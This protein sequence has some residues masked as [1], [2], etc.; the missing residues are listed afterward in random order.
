[1]NVYRVVK[2]VGSLI[3]DDVS[4]VAV[5]VPFGTSGFVTFSF[6]DGMDEK[7]TPATLKS[8]GIFATFYINLDPV[9]LGWER[10]F[11]P[12]EVVAIANS[13]H[14]IGNHG[15]LHKDFATL[16]AD[17]LYTEVVVSKFG[18][19]NMLGRRVS[20]LAYPYGSY[21]LSV[22]DL[23]LQYHD[24]ARGV[25]GSTGVD[26]GINAPTQ[27]RYALN[28]MCPLSTTSVADVKAMI[29]RAKSTKQWLILCFHQFDQPPSAPYSYKTTDL[30]QIVAY[31]KQNT[32]IITVQ[33]GMANYL[34][35]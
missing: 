2:N 32:K 9:I 31:A 7:T 25:E 18:L 5:P 6:D 28:A 1:M 20:T 24:A 3:I 26:A 10:Y 16:S 19:E 8:L 30:Q 23:V 14:E 15:G 29:N 11:T 12:S 34:V 13:G 27:D 21:T 33:Q 35:Q 17:D 4:L 22:I